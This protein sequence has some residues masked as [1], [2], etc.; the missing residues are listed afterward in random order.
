M[1]VLP[2]VRN[3]FLFVLAASLT[4]YRPA[5]MEEQGIRVLILSGRN[6]HDW[7]QTEAV[8]Q[9]MLQTHEKFHA[10][11]T[12][13]PD[14]L[15]FQSLQP[16]DVLVSNWN[17]WPEKNL[18]WSET[19]EKGLLEFIRQGGG[20]VTFHASSSAFYTWDEFREISTASWEE[21]T[22]HGKMSPVRVEIHSQDHPVTRGLSD[23]FIF[24]ELWMDARSNDRYTPLAYA[25]K[26]DEEE[27]AGEKQEAAMVA[28][29]G[30]GRIFH[31]ILGHDARTMRNTGFETLLIRGIEWAATG[32][33][34]N[35]IPQELNPSPAPEQ[36][37]YHWI[38]NDS[39]LALF[40]HEEVIW[41]FNFNNRYG[42][43]YFHPVYRGKTRFT[44]LS[45]DDHRWHLG[46]WFSWKYI[47]GINYWEY[48]GDGFKSEGITRITDISISREADFSARIEL[49]IQYHP[50][51]DV[52]AL[53]ET[54]IVL[55]SAPEKGCLSMD[56]EF[57]FEALSDTVFLDR[58][59]IQGEAGGKSWGGYAGLSLRFNQDFTDAQWI[60][61]GEADE[62]NG[63][64]EAWLL[65]GFSGLH[66]EKA[67][68]AL[69]ISDQTRRSGEGW[70]LI[71]D[72][73][74]PFYYVSPA[75]LYLAPLTLLRGEHL[76][77][78]YRVNH[79]SGIPNTGELR[80]QYR[81]YINP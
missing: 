62:V 50:E 63:S 72:P 43:P 65:M 16:Y 61:P 4:G 38:Q 5:V 21:H 45:P 37:S 69:F 46:Q 15:T 13:R 36:D 79:L 49:E 39:L 57:N 28:E 68:S 20:L 42:K 70:Y 30:K 17:S 9:R 31:T 60:S 48:V 33:V 19:T 54:R 74:V 81:E 44:S 2:A 24:D 26:A 55:V 35:V 67:G 27:L 47:N 12:I 75:C 56:Y 32:Q 66:G 25:S 80:R 59:P 77:L 3:A 23:F 18:R 11:L 78:K 40:N 1:R 14:T 52:P 10:D 34:S 76:Q 6:N 73:E 29:Y 41:Q 58:T 7:K 71:N 53:R 64:E 8:L 22:H 51:G